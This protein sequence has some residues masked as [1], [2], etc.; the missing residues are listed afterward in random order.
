V[1]R[2]VTVPDVPRTGDEIR[3]AVEQGTPEEVGRHLHNRL[4]AAAERLCPEVAAIQQQLTALNPAGALMSGSGSS[5]FA[6][7]RDRTEALRLARAL[8]R[9]PGGPRIASVH[10]VRSCS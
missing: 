6:L 8:R 5:L 3:R 10:L 1:Y 7:G 4:Q 2:E 9:D